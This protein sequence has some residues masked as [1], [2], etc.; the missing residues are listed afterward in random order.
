MAKISRRA[1]LKRSVALGAGAVLMLYSDGSYKLTFAQGGP[2]IYQ[3]RVIHTND[4]HARIEP[5]ILSDA[6]TIRSTPTPAVTRLF[7]GLSRRKTLFDQFRSDATTNGQNILFLDAGDVFQGTLFFN[8]FSGQADLDF[9]ID[10]GYDAMTIGNHEFDKGPQPLVDFIKG[11]KGQDG[12]IVKPTTFPVV[13]ANITATDS[14]LAPVLTNGAAVPGQ[15]IGAYTLIDK[16]GKKIGIFGLTTPET[17][18]SSSP[19]AGIDFGDPITVA[20][21]V[22]TQLKGLGADYIIALTHI[23]YGKTALT[24]NEIATGSDLDLAAKVDGID[25]IVGGHSHTPLLPDDTSTLGPIGV[26]RVGPYA[27]V[28]NSPDGSPTLVVTDWEW[29]KWIGDITIGFDAAGVVSQI[30]GTV[31]PVWADYVPTTRAPI[32]GEP[33]P[34]AKDQ[35]FADRIAVYSAQVDALNK[36][37]IGTTSFLIEGGSSKG[38]RTRETTGGDIITDAMLLRAKAFAFPDGKT[39]DICITNSGGIRAEIQPGDVT[40]GS[41]IT[42]LPFGNTIATVDLTGAQVVAALENGV[43]QVEANGGRFPQ[44]SGLRYAWN[45]GGMPALQQ[46]EVPNRPAQKGTRILSVDIK[47]A[48][49]T[50][51]PIDPVKVYRVVTNNFML[52]GGDGYFVFTKA[53]DRSGSGV[54]GGTNQYDTQIILA[55]AVQDYITTNSPLTA[56]TQGRV[57]GVAAIL[58]VVTKEV[59]V[60]N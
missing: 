28:V 55:D 21:S 39:A 12:S 23:G 33:L 3:L 40:V 36:Q 42:V 56:P 35:G 11:L 31:H 57:L 17:K 27:T 44:V 38:Y 1:F 51:S 43:S 47:N 7:G 6:V 5:Q 59:T 29:G 15:K 10:L 45:K 18:I 49:G 34:V 54:G 2:P 26:T 50:Y 9:Y 46:N 60:T 58:P 41:V 8:L 13:S 22:V 20:Q 32:E 48:D 25:L 30:S 53:G 37:K 4:H 14:V 16:G 19:G 24:P 52:T